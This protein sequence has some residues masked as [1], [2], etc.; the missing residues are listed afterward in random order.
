[1]TQSHFHRRQNHHAFTLVEVALAT[2]ITAVG[3]IAIL[4]LLPT[5]LSMARAAADRTIA[6]TIANDAFSQLRMDPFGAVFVCT[7]SNCSSG[8]TIDLRN[9][10]SITYGYTQSGALPSAGENVY[11][12]TRLTYT[13]TLTGL[14]E[15]RAIITWP[16]TASAPANTNIF[17]T[18]VAWY[19]R[20]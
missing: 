4:G 1:M 15:V 8:P 12:R 19:D 5:G 6:A 11:F 13:N 7:N 18:Q 20:L 10:A 17:A 9:N 16:A 3:I 2:A 14:S